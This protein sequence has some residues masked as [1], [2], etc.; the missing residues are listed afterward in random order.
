MR[1]FALLA[2]AGCHVSGGG[3]ATITDD[4]GQ[5][6]VALAGCA[7]GDL[8]EQLAIVGELRDSYHEMIVCGG[9]ALSF[10]DAIVNVIA[11][12]A[13]GR[14]G[15]SQ[16]RYQGNGTYATAN[17]MMMIKTALAGGGGIGFD[18]L[19]PQ[20]YLA[21]I[22]ID[23]SGGID[24]AMRGGSPWQ[25]AARA[26]G[27]IDVRFT[28]QGPGYVL[29]GL[30]ADE[31]RGRALHVDPKRIAKALGDAITVANR[32][33]VQNEQG[34]TVIHYVLDGAPEKLGDVL[35]NKHVPMQLASIEAT[36][37]STGQTIRITDWTMQFRG[38]GTTV[39]DGAIS[40]D[41]DGGAFPYSVRFT[42][43]H[44]KEPDIELRCR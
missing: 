36:R 5:P 38:D 13:L 26:A 32:I 15:P 20:S 21:G 35:A 14:G 22:E 29:L 44:R 10:D 24:A 7:A 31:V 17:G 1:T 9:L 34:D 18:V 4:L 23:A 43:P 19:D 28:G 40:L 2:L 30:T 27:S 3:S 25:M 12:A 6:Q 37:K 16:L 11:H 39:L 33:D 42:Y 8:K 41:V